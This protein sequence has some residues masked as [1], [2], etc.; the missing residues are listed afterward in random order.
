MGEANDGSDE[1]AHTGSEG[2]TNAEAPRGGTQGSGNT[3]A[4]GERRQ[5][6]SDTQKEQSLDQVCVAPHGD[7]ESFELGVV[8]GRYLVDGIGADAMAEHG[9]AIS[10]GHQAVAEFRLRSSERA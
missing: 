7:R 5:G 6:R 9:A 4:T 1:E 2:R 3:Q 8:I 10:Q